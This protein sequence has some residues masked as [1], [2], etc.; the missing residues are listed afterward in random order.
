MAVQLNL[1]YRTILLMLHIGLKISII[2]NLAIKKV[3]QSELFK[4]LSF[5]EEDL[6]PQQVKPIV[7]NEPEIEK[8][9]IIEDQSKTPQSTPSQENAKNPKKKKIGNPKSKKS[10]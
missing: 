4:K 9:E 10:N 3:V 8:I 1:T 7:L 2:V 5:Q 6:K